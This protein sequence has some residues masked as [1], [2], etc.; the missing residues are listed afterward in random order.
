MRS[1]LREPITAVDSVD[2]QVEKGEVFGVL[3]PN[4]AGKTTLFKILTTMLVPTA[5]SA[6]IAG[7]S[8]PT[9]EIGVRN[10]IRLV[11]SE[12]RSFKQPDDLAPMKTAPSI[13][14]S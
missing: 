2:L 9:D 6:S 14:P 12:E 7:H 4:G 10:N 5:G 1:P 11:T 3:G 8:V 13:D